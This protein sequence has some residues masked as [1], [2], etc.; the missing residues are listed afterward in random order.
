[1]ADHGPWT[2][3]ASGARGHASDRLLVDGVVSVETPTAVRM[4][5]GSN[6]ACVGLASVIADMSPE[7]SA[8][9][10][11]L[12]SSSG[13][14]RMPSFCG[15]LHRNMSICRRL[16]RLCSRRALDRPDRGCG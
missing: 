10:R 7:G 16:P 2:R 8:S 6:V 4:E 15:E 5:L 9:T 3:P 14:R 12:G 13:V 1:M 11:A